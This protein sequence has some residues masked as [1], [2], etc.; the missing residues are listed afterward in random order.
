MI[1]SGDYNQSFLANKNAST[2]A[3]SKGVNYET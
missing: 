2:F 3:C 1:I